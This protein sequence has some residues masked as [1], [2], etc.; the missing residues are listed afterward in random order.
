MRLPAFLFVLV[1][2]VAFGA[3]QPAPDTT[4]TAK[5][6][7]QGYRETVIL[8]KP[9]AA[10]R[11]TADAEEARDGVRVVDKLAR[12]GDLRVVEV[13]PGETP[14]DAIARLRASGRYEF[15]EP[16]YLRHLATEPNDPSF[17][18]GALWAMKNTGQNNG[19]A[20][21]DISATAAWDVIHDA[22]TVV[23]AVIDTGVNINHPDLAANIWTNPAPTVGDVHGVKIINR[24]SSGSPLDDNG[25]GTHVAGTIGAIGNNANNVAGI[26]WHVQI[27][28]IKVF[29]ASGNGASVSDI[30]RGIQYAIDH[31]A[32]LINAS[33]GESGSTGFTDTEFAAMQAARDAGIIFVAA[34]GNSTANMDVTPF[35]PASYALDNVIAV[36]AS[37][38]RDEVASFSNYGA[39]VDLYA[40]G[41]EIVSLS[42][43]DLNN[44]ATLS[45]TSMAAPHVTGTLALLK[46][47]FPNDDYHQLI[48]R[49]RRGVD[50]QP[51]FAGKA[52]TSGRLNL[53]KA[54]TTTTNRPFNDDFA[55]RPRLNSNNLSIRADNTGATAEP[56][57]PA[58]AG[59][60]AAGSLWWEWVSPVTGTVT[61]DTI[62]SAYDTRVALYTG[63]ALGTLTLVAQ[64]DDAPTNNRA[65]LTFAARAGTAYEIAIDGKFGGTGLTLL[66]LGTTPAND[67]FATPEIL[68]GDS[69]RVTETNLHCSREPNEPKMFFDGGLSLW[70]RWTAP[71]TGTYQISVVSADY[72]PT[73]GVFTGNDFASLVRVAEARGSN[74]NGALATLNAIAGTTY[75][76]VTDAPSALNVG[77][78]TLTLV[79]SLW[80]AN[81]NNSITSP[82][83][84]GADGTIYVGSTDNSLYAFNPDA[85]LKWS[86]A[87]ASAID[88]ASALVGGDGTVY[89]AS[90]FSVS[91]EL[92]ALNPDG[93]L[94]WTHRFGASLPAAN[95]PALAADGTLYIKPSDGLLYALNSADGSEKWHYDVHGVASYSSPVIAPDGTIYLGSEDHY[96]Y[97]L[98]PDGTLKWRYQSDNDIYTTPALDSAGNIYFGVLNSGKFYSVRA[99]GTLRWVYSGASLGTSSSPALSA[100]GSTAYFGGYDGKLHAVNTANGTRRWAYTLGAEVRSSSPAVDANGVI[101]IGCYDY[102]LYALNSD[103]TLK[104][105]W[106]A[107]NWIRSSPTISGNT[108]YVGSN[109]H[110]LYAFNI[111][112]GPADGPWPQYRNNPRHLGRAVAA[113]TITVQP[114]SK[115]VALGASVALT[116]AASDSGA[117]YQWQ[118]NGSPLAG[119]TGSS[120]NLANVQPANTGI[121]TAVASTGGATTATA[122][123]VV[124][125]TTA[126]KVEGFGS[127]VGSNIVHPNGNVYDQVLLQGA[128]VSITADPGQVVRLSFIDLT[129]DIVQVEF[130]GAGTL[131]L[132][133]DNASGPAAPENYNQPGVNYMKGHAGIVIS[134]ADETTNVSIFSVGKANAVN[135]S[136]F[137]S[138]V[139]YDAVADLA[140]LAILSANGKF[141]GLRAANASFTAVKGLTGIYAPDVQFTGDVYVGDIHASDAATP[142]LRLGASSVVQI[143]GGDLSQPNNRAVQ[144]SGI[145]QLKFVNGT[146]SAGDPLPA[147]AI[148]GRLEQN[149]V[150]VTAQIAV[151]PSP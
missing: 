32:N 15:V 58:H 28:P 51:L 137:R 49:L 72:D 39:A 140:Y 119:A 7:A 120:L 70:Y 85:S 80:Q 129:K 87:T 96:L 38:R 131:S 148:R 54:L 122:P 130:S 68:N 40:P 112:A 37:T 107:G 65:R 118:L 81:T 34:A 146:T 30:A 78:F 95:S 110:K 147:Q 73:L 113:P 105:T 13:E 66:N 42:Y 27:M 45:G 124:G 143:N 20:G 60:A 64:N 33:Y 97:A 74:G 71:R 127:E 25:H 8:A 10:R 9:K 102:K 86:Y 91:G 35:Y 26:A 125:V 23:V 4:F 47:E 103:G 48:N 98:R 101:Y 67:M 99:D 5:E 3:P 114:A 121:Y 117:S 44:P 84:V 31:H 36:G 11:A 59:L 150:D 123:A 61:I 145:T 134:G 57:E 62:G 63:N 90:G 116:A 106:D 6:L 69:V 149:G 151:A 100:D 75:N 17:V 136:L 89:V 126:N 52:Q 94:K 144:V 41:Q 111:G 88:G 56:G 12:I 21:A 77:T 18:S 138:D 50:R 79:D 142:V 104:R 22:P 16:D 2:A 14:Q 93:T 109:D 132:V 29:P 76:I 55:D 19:I 141:G 53:L 43:T 82:P 128:S 83:S 24:V 115:S 135:Q 108:L 133:L 92:D 1:A 46:A 139:R